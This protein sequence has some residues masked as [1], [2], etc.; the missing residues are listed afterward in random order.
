M[1]EI[2][3]F[4]RG[5]SSSANNAALNVQ[6][7]STTPTTQLTFTSGATGDIHL[8]YNGG[9]ADPDTQVIVNGVTQN[10]TVQF[11]GTLPLTNKLANV[12]GQNLRG[13]EIVVITLSNGKRYFFLTNGTTSAATMSAFPNGAHAIGNVS[14]TGPIL[15]CFLRGTLIDTPDGERPIEALQIGDLVLNVSGDAIPLRW[16]G[17]RTV[18][19]IELLLYPNLRPVIIETGHFGP[20]LPHSTLCLSPQHRI[21]MTGW[22]VE[23]FFGCDDVL[24]PAGQLPCAVS[25]PSPAAGPIEYFH[26]LFDQHEIIWSNGLATESFQL[27][28]RGLLSLEPDDVAAILGP[29]DAVSQTEMADRPDCSRS[30]RNFETKVLVGSFHPAASIPLLTQSR[31]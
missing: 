20:G 4:A 5:D 25:R 29:K 7:T 18:S 2:V 14:N 3:F 16:V 26:L 9:L 13:Q 15:V 21:A 27:G 11:S 17:S 22:Q 24:V 1:T 19:Q 8:D 23:L 10:F 30:L 6:G 12:N 31:C 28:E